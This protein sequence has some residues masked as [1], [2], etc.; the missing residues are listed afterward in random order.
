MQIGLNV[1]NLFDSKTATNI[2]SS[3]STFNIDSGI[4]SHAD[5]FKGFDA[6]SK[7]P[8][9]SKSPTYGSA[10]EFQGP[11]SVRLSVKFIF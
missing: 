3:Y 10:S 2:S 4:V 9:N 6:A 1:L 11:R 5:F 8:A 7:I